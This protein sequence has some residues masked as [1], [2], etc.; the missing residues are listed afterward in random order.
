MA[1][2]SHTVRFIERMQALVDHPLEVTR[3]R[4]LA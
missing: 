4:L 3:A 1:G 2:N